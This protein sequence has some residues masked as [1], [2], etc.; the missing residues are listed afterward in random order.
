MGDYAG[1]FAGKHLYR[2]YE[3]GPGLASISYAVLRIFT[4]SSHLS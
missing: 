3:R 1:L 2:A 4:P